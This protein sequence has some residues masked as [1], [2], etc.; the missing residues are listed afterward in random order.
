ML[1]QKVKKTKIIIQFLVFLGIL[2][3]VIVSAS[4]ISVIRDF[5]GQASGEVA[6]IHVYTKK[7]LG[8]YNR[9]WR[10]LAQGGEDHN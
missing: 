6:D 8:N 4:Q 5:F 9:P 7:I 3:S 1:S 2:I 10:N